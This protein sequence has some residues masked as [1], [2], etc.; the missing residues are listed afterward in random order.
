MKKIGRSTPAAAIRR[1]DRNAR[2]PSK[3][4]LFLNTVRSGS[5]ARGLD[6]KEFCDTY[7]VTLDTFTRLTGFSPRAV[8]HWSRGRKP[9]ESTT[10]RLMELK[11]IFNALE[12]LVSRETIGLW[13][14]EPNP[15]FHG[16]TPLQVIERGEADRIW[17]MICEL[18]SGEPG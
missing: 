6:V 4:L 18:E 1:V 9:S 12:R 13:I 14:K 3:A 11:R 5:M 17:R 8:A 16:S 15:A 7:Q 2:M 10:R